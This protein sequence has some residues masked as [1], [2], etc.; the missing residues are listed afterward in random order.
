[1]TDELAA[2]IN[3]LADAIA[4]SNEKMA[5]IEI[6]TPGKGGCIKFSFDPSNEN[7]ALNVAGHV[8]TVLEY[9]QGE[10][11]EKQEKK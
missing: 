4:K 7:E 6:G 2:A 9:T 3:R 11:A 5:S 1:M 10:Y 8:F